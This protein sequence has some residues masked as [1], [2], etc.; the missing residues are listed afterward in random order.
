MKLAL[1]EERDY[2]MEQYGK[3]LATMNFKSKVGFIRWSRKSWR[4]S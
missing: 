2:R 4:I 3:N 1:H